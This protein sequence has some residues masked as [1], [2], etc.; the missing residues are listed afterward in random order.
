M[1][2][3]ALAAQGSWGGRL[4]RTWVPSPGPGSGGEPA[5]SRFGRAEAEERPWPPDG[6]SQRPP[7]PAGSRLHHGSQPAASANH[8]WLSSLNPVEVLLSHQQLQLAAAAA[9]GTRCLR[10]A[11]GQMCLQPRLEPKK[12]CRFPP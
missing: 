2:L 3:G 7:A 12:S 9:L 10:R 1:R 5:R 6:A 4:G 8:L 11:Q